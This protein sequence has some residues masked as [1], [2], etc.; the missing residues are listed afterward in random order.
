MK[1]VLIIVACLVFCGA[2]AFGGYYFYTHRTV[3]VYDKYH[4]SVVMLCNKYVYKLALNDEILYFNYDPETNEI[5]NMK[6]SLADA[7]EN[8]MMCY[9][10]GFFID[11]EGRIATNRHVVHDWNGEFQ[12][13]FIQYFRPKF[14]K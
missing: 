12:D 9:G 2:A 7:E 1:R 13:K 5:S 4:K 3:N 8:A 14:E 6:S 10:T 11:N